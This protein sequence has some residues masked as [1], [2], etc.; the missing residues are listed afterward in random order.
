MLDIKSIFAELK[1]LGKTK[2]S[3]DKD[4]IQ[5]HMLDNSVLIEQ[6]VDSLIAELPSRVRAAAQW[7]SSV[8]RFDTKCIITHL[9]TLKKLISLG[10]PIKELEG[11][12]HTN[13]SRRHYYKIDLLVVDVLDTIKGLPENKLKATERWALV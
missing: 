5:K 8:I 10:L 13:E 7:N 11:T 9:L 3:L 1:E 4:L 2:N 12:F 6:H